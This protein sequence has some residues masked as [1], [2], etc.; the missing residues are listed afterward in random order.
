MKKLFVFLVSLITMM[1]ITGCVNNAAA[2][3]SSVE[4]SSVSSSEAA[5]SAAVVESSV[6]AASEGSSQK[7]PWPTQEWSKASPKEQ[8]LNPDILAKADARIAE[9]YPNVYS[10]LVVRHGYLVYEKYYQGMSA[11]NANPVYSVTKSVLSALTGIAIRERLITG[12]DQKVSELL[13][14][15][16]KDIDDIRK[17]DITVKNVLTMSGGLE[18]IDKDYYS[19][20]SSPDWFAYTLKK[21][22]VDKPGEKF[23]YNT[24]L[25]HFLSR[26]ITNTSGISTKDFAQKYLF[27]QIGI[28][29]KNWDKDSTG[30]Y[31]GGAGLYLTPQDMARFGYLYLNNGIWDG[32]QVIPAEWVKE[33]STKQISVE[34]G[35]DYGYLFWMRKTTNTATGKD[36]FTYQADGAGGQKIII[37]PEQNM[38]AVVTA[39]VN[40]SSKDGLDT[41]RIVADFVAQ[42]VVE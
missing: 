15:Y 27:S 4:V 18:S 23:V 41:Q 11:E 32:K 7:A 10:L 39:G 9:N 5:S 25:T 30:C 28:N 42:A 26:I 16:Y 34:N 6:S 21:P 19:F 17:K 13:P 20:F 12:I 38:V 37:F 24:G 33:S 1:S 29:A 3:V 35:V 22:L 31:G 14:D 8:G 36:I 2:A 40:L